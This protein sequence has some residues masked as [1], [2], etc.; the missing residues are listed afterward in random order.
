MFAAYNVIDLMSEGRPA[1]RVKT[2]FAAIL[3][4]ADNF[5]PNGFW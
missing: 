4:S 2:V 3:R 5:L 1:F